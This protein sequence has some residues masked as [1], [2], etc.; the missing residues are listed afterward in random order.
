MGR[1]QKTCKRIYKR[2]IETGDHKR[3][4]KR[5]YHIVTLP[6]VDRLI[7]K[8]VEAD[9]SITTKALKSELNLRVSESTIR[10]R[11]NENSL[12]SLLAT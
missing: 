3:A 5:K 10:N 9:P 1:N 7:L 8:A 2:F 6:E 4:K 12:K 11:L